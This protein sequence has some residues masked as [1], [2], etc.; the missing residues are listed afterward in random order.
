MQALVLSRE[1]IMHMV[2]NFTMFL[3]ALLLQIFRMGTKG[4][5]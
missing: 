5:L 1:R 4:D 3:P 2:V